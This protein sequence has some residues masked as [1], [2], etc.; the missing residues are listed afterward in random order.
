MPDEDPG[1][2]EIETGQV[3]R[4]VAAFPDITVGPVTRITAAFPDIEIG[5]VVRIAARGSDGLLLLVGDHE[6]EVARAGAELSGRVETV[7]IRVD[8]VGT[9]RK[10]TATVTRI[11]PPTA[12]RAS[13]AQA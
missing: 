3:V 8:A 5:K 1:F 4:I 9:D 11:D 13:G 12:G 10:A 7:T 2:A 6:L